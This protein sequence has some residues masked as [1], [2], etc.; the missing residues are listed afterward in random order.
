[1]RYTADL[2]FVGALTAFNITADDGARL[3]VDDT[4]VIDLWSV[5]SVSTPLSKI[6]TPA[7]GVHRVVVEYFEQ[8]GDA[9][10]SFTMAP[11]PTLVSGGSPVAVRLQ[12]P[13]AVV[14]NYNIDWF[15]GMPVGGPNQS[16]AVN[17]AGVLYA[18]SDASHTVSRLFKPTANTSLWVAFAGTGGTS[19]FGGDGFQSG[20]A[21]LNGPSGLAV[22]PNDEIFVADTGNRRIRRIDAVTGVITT[23]AG[24]G[25]TG[26]S[27]DG[28]LAVDA[29]LE[30]RDLAYGS[31]FLYVNDGG[32]RIRRIDLAT[33]RIEAFLGD[34]I[35]APGVE[36][37]SSS[38]FSLVNVNDIAFHE[39]QLVV[40]DVDRVVQLDVAYVAKPHIRVGQGSIT[41]EGSLGPDSLAMGVRSV[42]IV[43]TADGV[44]RTQPDLLYAEQNSNLIRTV[45][46]GHETVWTIA[47]TR[48]TPGTSGNG[49]P[50]TGALLTNVT[51]L[52]YYPGAN[53]TSKIYLID[54]S[55]T[56]TLRVLE[57]A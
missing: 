33:G 37:E 57:R 54:R 7:A 18:T 15:G 47:G 43:P 45:R 25:G 4:L 35:S 48:A 56:P 32:T 19:G 31:N 39:W 6:F 21:L 34:G 16:I 42:L 10:L 51:D 55:A 14:P 41:A 13:V 29:T 46:V 3:W 53:G 49:G 2:R 17:S 24:T 38:Q 40:S 52:A 22:G 8:S 36:G 1:L 23:F 9:G 28:V 44:S 12:P 11:S 30:P 50:A 5:G 27:G 20:V 26:S